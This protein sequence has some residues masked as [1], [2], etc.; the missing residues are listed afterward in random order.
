MSVCVSESRRPERERI[1]G[2]EGRRG[3]DQNKAVI[4]FG[5]SGKTFPKLL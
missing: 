2:K 5:V 3:R 1:G 4:G